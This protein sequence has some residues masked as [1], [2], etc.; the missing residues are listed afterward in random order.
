MPSMGYKESRFGEGEGKWGVSEGSLRS[1]ALNTSSLICLQ[2]L[3]VNGL[4]NVM[5]GLPRAWPIRLSENTRSLRLAQQMILWQS[6]PFTPVENPLGRWLL[7]SLGI[8]SAHFTMAWEAPWFQPPSSFSDFMLAP[9]YS[10]HSNPTGL[11]SVPET[12]RSSSLS[13][14]LLI[15]CC[16]WPSRSCSSQQ[17]SVIKVSA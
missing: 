7:V 9:L 2:T 3:W 5:P 16:R 15:C 11:V 14:N 6:S 17:F 10:F 13:Q 12:S 8:K 4:L 1:L